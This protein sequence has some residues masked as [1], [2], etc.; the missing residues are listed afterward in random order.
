[1]KFR[2]YNSI[3]N[4][5]RKLEIEAIK[6]AGFFE[7][8]YV[9]QEKVHGANLSFITN[10]DR[11]QTAKRTSLLKA[12]E[13]FYNFQEVRDRYAD[14][15]RQAYHLV[16]KLRPDASFIGIYGELFGGVYPHEDV[17]KVKG[18]TVVQKGIYYAPQN[19]FYAFDI[20]VDNEDYLSVEDANA[21]F[22]ELGFFYAKTLFSGKLED[23]LAYPNE[24]NSK[25]PTWF[26][27]PEL[28]NNV[29]EGTI[30]KPLAFL[31]LPTDSRVILKNKNEKWEENIRR[32]KGEKEPL[33]LSEGLIS[34]QEAI[35]DYVTANRLSNVVSKIGEVTQKDFGKLI[36]LF[37]KDVL[38][39]FY[40][41][42]AQPYEKLEK[43]EQKMLT[44]SLNKLAI[45]LIRR[46]L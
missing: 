20:R 29:T 7:E 41:D 6:E 45:N 15:I 17:A 28:A 31:C 25:I 8:T 18:S 35:A 34:L 30:I 10:G 32:H 27:L 40:K 33:V 42:F 36:G 13:K 4:S 14:Q 43:K 23:C 24:F 9:V 19:D 1:M 5:F 22:E 12:D 39:D 46:E 2:K 16:K 44:K 11:I 37:S 21:I 38:E 26:G 3:E